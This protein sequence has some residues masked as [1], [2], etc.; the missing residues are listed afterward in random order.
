VTLI[1]FAFGVMGDM[2]VIN[3]VGLWVRHAAVTF[4]QRHVTFFNLY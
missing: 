1:I 4:F 3:F 2:G